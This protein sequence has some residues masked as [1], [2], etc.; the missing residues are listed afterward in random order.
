MTGVGSGFA[1]LSRPPER[2]TSAISSLPN[3]RR[4]CR[5]SDRKRLSGQWETR[6]VLRAAIFCRSK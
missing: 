4:Q 3:N 5:F 1:V 2:A 6:S